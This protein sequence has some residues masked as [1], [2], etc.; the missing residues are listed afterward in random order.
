MINDSQRQHI[1]KLKQ[2]P[3]QGADPDW[4]KVFK[5]FNKAIESLGEGATDLAKSTAFG[6]IE[7]MVQ[8]VT[9]EVTLLA[10]RNEVLQ[11]SLN[12][13][14]Q[15]AA[16]LGYALDK[17]SDSYNPDKLRD[18]AAELNSIAKGY[19]NVIF[20]GKRN[21]GN[22]TAE[23]KLLLKNYDMMRKQLKLTDQQALS[24]T[25]FTSA[26]DMSLDKLAQYV[27][28]L[29]T[30]TDQTGLYTETLEQLAD[31]GALIRMSYAKTPE[32]ITKSAAKANL[33]G[34]SFKELVSISNKF[35]DIES[36]IGSELEL[37]LLSGKR[38]NSE[39]FRQAAAEQDMNK[40]AD[41]L[42]ETMDAM[43]E[44]SLDNIFSRQALA[45]TLGLEEERLM[46]IYE[47]MKNIEKTVGPV[48][49][50]FDKINKSTADTSKTAEQMANDEDKRLQA[51]ILQDSLRQKYGQTIN[52]TFKDAEAAAEHIQTINNALVAGQDTLVSGAQSLIKLLDNKVVKTLL[53]AYTAY[54]AV[55]GI[56]SGSPPVLE[57]AGASSG[58]VKTESA[59][60]VYISPAMGNAIYS[61]KENTLFNLSP[62]DEV[63]A[64]PGLGSMLSNRGVD[65]PAFNV[66]VTNK[67]ELDQLI[68]SVDIRRS[69]RMNG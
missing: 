41:S 61:A 57:R 68:T 5:D 3:R 11:T 67:F 56:T 16:K 43:G 65:T 37:Q 21:N 4:S 14:Q 44:S 27:S 51:E 62:R 54:N 7:K 59:N 39:K 52:A 15:A 31:A 48:A 46:E 34:V 60:D 69:E 12:M 26:K 64:A 47:H 63:A 19:S 18:Y 30:A 6:T 17:L 40:M 53:G 50:E 9:K 42:R 25:K 23:N 49:S 45:G 33:L 10:Q 66:Y 20:A 58:T 8:G 32:L 13:N 55:S 36:S 35:L 22:M 24:I 29:Q 2:Q 28:G 38:I 1:A